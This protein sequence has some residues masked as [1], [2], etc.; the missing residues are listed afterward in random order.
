MRILI[1]GGAGYIGGVLS[2]YLYDRNINFAVIDNLSTSVK[3]NLPP[4][5]IFYKGNIKNI[6]LLKK[7]LIKFKPTHII[8]LAASLDVA[9]SELNKKKYYINNIIN[10]KIF[11]KFFI[12]HNVKNFI[13]ASTAAVY[14]KNSLKKKIES[15]YIS[16]SSYYGKTKFKIEKYLLSYKNNYNL[17]I[18]ILRFFNVV[19]ADH[20]LRSG[21]L[22]KKSNQVFNSIC[23]SIINKD[24]FYIYGNNLPTQ[25]GT[26]VRDFVDIND[27]VKIIFFFISNKKSIKY[28]IFNI[29]TNKGHSVLEVL[30]LFKKFS[31]K[32]INFSFLGKRKGDA[33]HSV[34]SNT[35]LNKIYKF[36]FSSI[37]YSIN[38][39]YFFYKKNF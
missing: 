3:K 37:R 11:L 25:D 23:N 18:K 34:C 35:R 5:S 8:H 4:N 19:G 16:P 22:S 21:S 13:F 1:S 7:I 33:V 38:R 2:Y 9:E 15:K 27:L 10:S 12:K 30:N 39:H 32:N 31:G 29:G 26:C 14:S 36:K 17:N 6:N 20:K 24:K 28:D